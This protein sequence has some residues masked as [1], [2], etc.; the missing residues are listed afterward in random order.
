N[1]F[2]YELAEQTNNNWSNWKIK[3]SVPENEPYRISA[4]VTD[5]EGNENWDAVIVGL[6]ADKCKN[7]IP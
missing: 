1:Q 7:N 2:P 6:P 3:L 5:M 4:R